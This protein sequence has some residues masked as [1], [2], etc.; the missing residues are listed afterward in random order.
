[1]CRA[2][3]DCARHRKRAWKTRSDAYWDRHHQLEGEGKIKH[4]V[5]QCPERTKPRLVRMWT[6]EKSWTDVS[7]NAMP[8]K[9]VSHR[10]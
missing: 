7:V 5:E 1:M 6:L 8:A 3:N 2:R 9:A 4:S 10:R